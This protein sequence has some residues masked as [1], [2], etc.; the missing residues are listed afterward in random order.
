MYLVL[1]VYLLE[2]RVRGLPNTKLVHFSTHINLTAILLL[3][4]GVFEVRGVGLVV[5]GTVTR[6]KIGVN[7]VLYLGPDKAGA[8]IQVMVSAF[9]TLKCTAGIIWDDS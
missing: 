3:I 6:G 8:F 5:G 2:A 9:L 7:S 1:I 4:T